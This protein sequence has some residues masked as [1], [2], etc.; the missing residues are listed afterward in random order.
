MIVA[1]AFLKE[2]HMRI[3]T[4]V[5]SRS[6]LSLVDSSV[7]KIELPKNPSQQDV[8]IFVQVFSAYCNDNNVDIV[9]VNR[10]QTGG[11]RPGGTGTFI[12][13]GILLAVS[14]PKIVFAHHNTLLATERKQGT[15]KAY[16]PKSAD[17]GKAYD[18]AFEGLS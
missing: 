8:E 13:E 16:R 9:S 14:K 18:L 7:N 12:I 4:L 6:S 2:R 10:R 15:V 11:T 1:G 17:L 5:G 3:I